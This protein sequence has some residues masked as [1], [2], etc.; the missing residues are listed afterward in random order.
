MSRADAVSYCKDTAGAMVVIEDDVPCSDWEPTCS[1]L[2]REGVTISMRGPVGDFRMGTVPG[3][4][5]PP[6]KKPLVRCSSTCN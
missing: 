6:P 1:A 5:K 2:R 3:N 4:W